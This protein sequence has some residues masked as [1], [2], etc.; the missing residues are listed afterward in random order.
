MATLSRRNSE[1]QRQ[2][3]GCPVPPAVES[4]FSLVWFSRHI[5][6]KEEIQSLRRNLQRGGHCNTVPVVICRHTNVIDRPE[7]CGVSWTL[8]ILVLFH[9]ECSV[10]VQLHPR[11]H[12]EDCVACPSL[13]TYFGSSQQTSPP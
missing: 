1:K 11:L 2:H 8:L 5:A 12:K 10:H 3:A 13:Q 6:T 4:L 7:H 9:F